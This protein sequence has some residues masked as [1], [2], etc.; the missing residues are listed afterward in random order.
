MPADPLLP[1]VLSFIGGHFQR[2]LQTEPDPEAV[3]FASLAALQQPAQ[4]AP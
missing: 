1:T 4:E 3:I 2:E